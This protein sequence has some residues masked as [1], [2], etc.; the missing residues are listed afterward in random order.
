MSY[1]GCHRLNGI[2]F[3]YSVR[4]LPFWGNKRSWNEEA[5]FSDLRILL[6]F[7]ILCDRNRHNKLF[8][9]NNLASSHTMNT[10]IEKIMGNRKIWT[11]VKYMRVSCIKCS[12][13]LFFIGFN[14]CSTTVVTSAGLWWVFLCMCVCVYALCLFRFSCFIVLQLWIKIDLMWL[15]FDSD[16]QK[17]TL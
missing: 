17:K 14:E 7:F 6:L 3:C 9:Y 1:F 4:L 12:Q 15:F 13:W 8:E 2:K 10:L 5:K 11:V 16:P